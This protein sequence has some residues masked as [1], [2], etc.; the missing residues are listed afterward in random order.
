MTYATDGDT[1]G[2]VPQVRYA[3]WRGGD[4]IGILLDSPSKI[5]NLVRVT[6]LHNG[7]RQTTFETTE[8]T[9]V[10][11]TW[12]FGAGL[13]NWEHSLT[14]VPGALWPDARSQDEDEEET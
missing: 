4:R 11:G 9:P 13:F 1:C 3:S 6:F 8:V 14:I 12:Y 5:G 7:V 10:D 2:L